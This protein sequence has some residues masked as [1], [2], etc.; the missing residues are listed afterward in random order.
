MKSGSIFRSLSKRWEAC[1]AA[2]PSF[3]VSLA[4]TS[5]M[6]LSS[7]SC[8]AVLYAMNTKFKKSGSTQESSNPLGDLAAV[9]GFLIPPCTTYKYLLK[10]LERDSN[11]LHTDYIQ[12]LYQMSYPLE[13]CQ[14]LNLKLVTRPPLVPGLLCCGIHKT[15]QGTR[16]C[17]LR[18]RY[19]KGFWPLTCCK[20]ICVGHFYYCDLCARFC[21]NQDGDC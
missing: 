15:N 2:I 5:L 9:L 6:L 12:L 20:Q 19:R 18:L 16:D 21:S 14:E 13:R 11:P 10:V 1:R 3:S 17:V 4:T 8:F 7:W